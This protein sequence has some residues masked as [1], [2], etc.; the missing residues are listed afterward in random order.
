M[1]SKNIAF[2]SSDPLV[3]SVNPAG[4]LVV[5]GAGTANVQ[6]FHITDANVDPADVPVVVRNLVLIDSIAPTTVRCG[7]TLT[8]YGVGL[9]PIGET[10][11]RLDGLPAP[12]ASYQPNDPARPEREGA[13]EVLVFCILHSAFCTLHSTFCV[14]HSTFCTLHSALYILHSA[15]CTLHST[16]CTLH[17]NPCPLP[18]ASD[19]ALPIPPNYGSSPPWCQAGPSRRRRA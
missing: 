10:A 17:S 8:L 2:G 13:L 19:S 16:F 11:V 4:L 14:L 18:Q 5:A 12:I 3:A 15:L 1:P 9:Q 7:E 6:A